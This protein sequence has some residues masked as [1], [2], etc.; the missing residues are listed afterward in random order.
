MDFLLDLYATTR[1]DEMRNLVD[2]TP[3]QKEE[4]IRS[5]FQLQHTH[6]TKHYPGATLD[7]VVEGSRP[8][9]RLYV[10]R[11]PSEIRLM[12]VTLLPEKRNLGIGAELTRGIQREAS[13]S[14]RPIILHV[15]TWNPA[16]R[17]YRRLGFVEVAEEGINLQMEW[18]PR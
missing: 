4:F 11:V 13:A 16:L 6:Y 2:W 1:A 17:L 15:E 3:A 18:R 9:G 8:I 14:G 7:I 10:Y 5:Q 12:E